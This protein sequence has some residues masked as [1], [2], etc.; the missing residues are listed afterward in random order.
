MDYLKCVI[1]ESLRLHPPLP[2][3]LT[4]N[5]SANVKIKGYDAPTNTGVFVNVY[6]IQRDPKVW[7]KPEEFYHERFENN[8]IDFKWQD[9][10]FI[11]FGSGRRGCHGVSFGLAVVEFVLANLLHGF[12]WGLPGD[13][14]ML[15]N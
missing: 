11:P 2:T 10:Q 3:L 4:R 15:E 8:P 12:D 13:A 14:N 9:F 1:K 5:S 7:D 6:T